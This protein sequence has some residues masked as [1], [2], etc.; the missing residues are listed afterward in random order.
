MCLNACPFSRCY[1]FPIPLCLPQF[2]LTLGSGENGC[3]RGESSD[4]KGRAPEILIA[5]N[6]LIYIDSAANLHRIF[7]LANLHRTSQLIY[8]KSTC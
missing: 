1:D 8:T 7:L 4:E 3:S 2:A 5:T 6:Q